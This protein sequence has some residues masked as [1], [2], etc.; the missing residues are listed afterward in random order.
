MNFNNKC[1]LLLNIVFKWSLNDLIFDYNTRRKNLKKT[2]FVVS[3]SKWS[4][5]CKAGVN[6][7][8]IE[9]LK[10]MKMPCDSLLLFD[11]NKYPSFVVFEKVSNLFMNNNTKYLK[12][13]IVLFK[14][15]ELEDGINLNDVFDK[16]NRYAYEN[17]FQ[18]CSNI[19]S[20]DDMFHENVNFKKFIKTRIKN[21]F[22]LTA[23]LFEFLSSYNYAIFVS[24]LQTSQEQMSISSDLRTKKRALSP[25]QDLAVVLRKMQKG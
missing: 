7:Y 1:K 11:I 20:L 6:Y 2:S 9:D 5:K 19:T 24:N 3:D 15:D 17:D 23:D 18:I 4:S 25:R 22:T 14:C 13:F 8:P 12:S 21:K 10:D 16:M